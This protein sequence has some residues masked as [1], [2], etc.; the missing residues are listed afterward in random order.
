M[1][2][3]YNILSPGKQLI[4]DTP[5]LVVM[6][7]YN[8]KLYVNKAI[9]SIL[10][11][12]YQEFSFLI[13]NDGSTDGSDFIAKSY[14]DHRIIVFDQK[15][16]GPGSVMNFALD[17]AKTHNFQFITRMDA[18][19]ISHPHRLEKQISQL[20]N[21]PKIAACSC[22]AYY[23]D[24][25]TEQIIGTSTISTSPKLIRWEINHGLRGLILGACT[26]RTDALFQIGGFRKKFKYAEEVDVFLRLNEEYELI[27]SSDYL[28]KIR[29]HKD[30]FSLKNQNQNI[31]FQ[32]YALNC[33]KRRNTNRIERNY[34]DF[35]KSLGLVDKFRIWREKRLLILWQYNLGNRNWCKI[36]L[37][38]ILDP[39]RVILRIIR[40]LN[41]QLK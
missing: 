1:N 32:F 6:P 40:R 30:S 28:Y 34:I 17:F 25:V 37:A 5:V 41:L 24:S 36:F 15:N 11:Q 29:F 10:N 4:R 13:I 14:N 31:S 22:N 33:A 20:K 38:S 8:A 27:N 23:I 7:L 39:R 19:D 12:S 21:Y 3:D 26:F 35:V 18:D 16:K 9:E 2:S